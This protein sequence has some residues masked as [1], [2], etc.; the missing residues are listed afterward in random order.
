[1]KEHTGL[2][3]TDGTDICDGDV[4]VL[5]HDTE[6]QKKLV[7]YSRYVCWSDEH[8]AYIVTYLGGADEFLGKAVRDPNCRKVEKAK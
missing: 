6:S 1:M 5:W 4:I 8:A 2:K 7:P 3:Y